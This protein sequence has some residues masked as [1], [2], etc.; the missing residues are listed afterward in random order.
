MTRRL[1]LLVFLL[2]SSLGADGANL[3]VPLPGRTALTVTNG[4]GE[5]ARVAVVF[6]GAPNERTIVN[7]TLAA[8]ES[9]LVGDVPEGAT[10]ARIYSPGDVAAR[11][12]AIPA[13]SVDALAT[14][15]ILG[16]LPSGASVGLANPW[17]L[18]ATVTLDA[19]TVFV[20]PFAVVHVPAGAA[21]VRVQ[22][23]VGVYAYALAPQTTVLP[24]GA[25][26]SAS[27]TPPCSEPVP[28]TGATLATDRWLVVTRPGTTV[29]FTRS[30]IAP[31]AVLDE[32]P[33]FLADLTAAQVARLR[34][35]SAVELLE[36]P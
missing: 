8:G 1:F 11:A 27:M 19:G 32:V 33:A 31:A 13:I 35:D 5:P 30:G 25:L 3:L 21:S 20:P 23:P 34:C 4:E 17:P 2:S 28:A 12:E 16:G 15:Q 14:D 9:S 6:Y 36:R 29:D 22:S 18:A 24:A 7:F 26:R 10:M